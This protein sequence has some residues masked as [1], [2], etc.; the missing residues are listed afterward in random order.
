[1]GG[2]VRRSLDQSFARIEHTLRPRGPSNDR[3]THV[4]RLPPIVARPTRSRGEVRRSLGIDGSSRFAVV[5]LNPHF[6]D[7]ELAGAIEVSLRSA[8]YV[9]RG[10]SEAQA[11]RPGWVARDPRLV[12][13][14]AAADLFVSAPGMAS[15]EQ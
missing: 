13:L 8:G 7:P 1:F 3:L 14:I 5:Y 4:R 15:L 10:V 9:V 11:G 12:D 6:R 2:T